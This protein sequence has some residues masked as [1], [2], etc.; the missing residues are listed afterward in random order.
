MGVRESGGSDVIFSSVEL[1][2]YYSSLGED[3]APMDRSHGALPVT[4][5]DYG[6]DFLFPML[7]TGR[8]LMQ[9]VELNLRRWGWTG[10]QLGSFG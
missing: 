6:H 4:P 3:D 7:L 8:F 5:A 10:F 9:S 2:N 1:S